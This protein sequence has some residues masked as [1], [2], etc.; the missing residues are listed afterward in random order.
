M[1]PE[2]LEVL[3]GIDLDEYDVEEIVDHE[4]EGRN[5][6]NWKFHFRWAGYELDKDF[7]LHWTSQRPFGF[8]RL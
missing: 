7:W 4:E 8:E 2:V 6:M 1:I 3:A 5:P